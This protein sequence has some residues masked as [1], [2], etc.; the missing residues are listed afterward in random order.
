MSDVF[1]SSKLEAENESNAIIMRETMLQ[2]TNNLAIGV[3][4]LPGVYNLMEVNDMMNSCNQRYK[5]LLRNH[6]ENIAKLGNEFSGFDKNLAEQ[7]GISQ[8]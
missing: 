7:M 4:N 6:A 8:E 1:K 3:T 2:S 5:N